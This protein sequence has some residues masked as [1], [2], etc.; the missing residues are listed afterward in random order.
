MLVKDASAL[1]APDSPA[2]STTSLPYGDGPAD[3][4]RSARREQPDSGAPPAAQPRS[5][6][7]SRRA[8]TSPTHN[9]LRRSARRAR[10]RGAGSVWSPGSRL[11]RRG[12]DGRAPAYAAAAG[13]SGSCSKGSAVGGT[14]APAPRRRARGTPGRLPAPAP[15]TPPA[16]LARAAALCAHTPGPTS[17]PSQS[18]ADEG[19]RPECESCGGSGTVVSEASC[20]GFAGVAHFACG[21]CRGCCSPGTDSLLTSARR[22]GHVGLAAGVLVQPVERRRR[23]LF[24]LPGQRAHG[25]QQLPRRRHSG[26]HR[27]THR[28]PQRAQRQLQA[29]PLSAAGSRRGVVAASTLVRARHTRRPAPPPPR[30]PS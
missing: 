20:L 5:R 9:V 29:R 13:G 14:G 17:K 28:H 23:R 2:R 25:L 11:V 30:R 7:P 18:Q 8:S 22:P 26:A 19:P 15:R 16:S 6:G 12:L 24:N 10:R 27:G 1:D 21:L 4:R 3:D